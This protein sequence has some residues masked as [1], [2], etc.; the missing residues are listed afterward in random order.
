[1]SAAW[2]IATWCWNTFLA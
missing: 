1:M 2:T